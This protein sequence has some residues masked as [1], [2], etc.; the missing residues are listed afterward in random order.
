MKTEQGK[1][2]KERKQEG[3]MRNKWPKNAGENRETSACRMHP[4]RTRGAQLVKHQ[5]VINAQY[6]EYEA[7][8]EYVLIS[9][10][11]RRFEQ[12]GN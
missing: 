3:K 11:K 2:V 8:D 4:D 12:G 1:I 9:S 7:S 6:T 10:N 5:H